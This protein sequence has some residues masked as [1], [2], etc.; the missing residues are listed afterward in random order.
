MAR[1]WSNLNLPGALHY[2]TGN[3]LDR[4]PVFTDPECCRVFC[5]TALPPVVR[6]WL[7]PSVRGCPSVS[8]YAARPETRENPPKGHSPS[9][10][11]SDLRKGK[12]TSAK[13]TQAAKPF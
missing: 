4:I 11:W 9:Q 6:M 3:F 10:E 7:C 2:I 8:G 5:N 1:N 12:A 13:P